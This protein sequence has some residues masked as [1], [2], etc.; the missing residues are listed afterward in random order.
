MNLT[1]DWVKVKHKADFI[2]FN[3]HQAQLITALANSM[4]VENVLLKALREAIRAGEILDKDMIKEALVLVIEKYTIRDLT[5]LN[6]MLRD[7]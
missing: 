2:E 6:R 4:T 7:K 3:V 1:E 5:E